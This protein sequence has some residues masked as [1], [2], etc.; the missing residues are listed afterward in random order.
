VLH[1][2]IDGPVDDRDDEQGDEVRERREH[3]AD[4]DEKHPGAAVEV[5]LKVKLFVAAGGAALD[6]VRR[7]DG[8]CGAAF[9]ARVR[10][11][12]PFP[13]ETRITMSTEEVDAGHAPLFCSF[14]V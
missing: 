9:L 5:F 11:L 4:D 8:V 2:A 12:A 7:G 3:R 1:E 14:D 13:S 10:G 6:D